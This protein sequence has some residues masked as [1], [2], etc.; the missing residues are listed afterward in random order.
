MVTTLAWALYAL[1]LLAALFAGLR[2]IITND[3]SYAWV[4]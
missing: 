1:T 3:P 2:W 4:E